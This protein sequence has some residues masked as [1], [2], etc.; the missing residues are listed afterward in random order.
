MEDH[1][2]ETA[3]IQPYKMTVIVL[4]YNQAHFLK[5]AVESVLM[6]ETDFPWQLI[7]TDDHSTKDNS[8]ELI[9]EYASRYPEKIK[10]LINDENG[11]TLQNTLRAKV[12]TRTPY[13]TVLDGDDYWT[14]PHYL[15]DAVN[16][17]DAHPDTTIYGRNVIRLYP[18]GTEAPFFPTSYASGTYTRQDLF[19]GKP[20]GVHT[21]GAVFRNVIF[22]KGIPPVM[23]EAVGT[24]SERSF[25][26]DTARF[27]MHLK[28][29][30]F[31]FLNKPSGVYRILSQGIWS[32]LSSTE[33][34]S[35]EAQLG[36]DMGEYYGEGSS[37]FVEK[38]YGCML[39]SL[40]NLSSQEAELKD[41]DAFHQRM[42]N[43]L[44]YCVR[45]K[46]CLQEFSYLLNCVSVKE[47]CLIILAKIRRRICGR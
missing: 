10:A 16:Y 1:H 44:E 40:T 2:T 34:L 15:Q 24:V 18:D 37:F 31:Y 33:Q 39:R 29:G 28:E 17:L 26:G 25:E 14:D 11:K 8:V 35:L 38:A 41:A 12:Y 6:Q 4:S 21:A 46:A 45:N 3:A 32:G 7:I 20:L 5:Q 36:R 13:F 9:R 27:F 30:N 43:V 23:K 42:A 47:L 22:S 19:E